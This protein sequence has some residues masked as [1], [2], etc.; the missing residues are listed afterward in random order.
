MGWAKRLWKR[1][2]AG[3]ARGE[4]LRQEE[5]ERLK[6]LADAWK[7]TAKCKFDS[8]K[9]QKPEDEFGK[10]FIQHGAMCY[11]N[12]AMEL[13]NLISSIQNEILANSSGDQK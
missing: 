5:I 8:A 2:F 4:G 10:R 1:W 13:G 9:A 3:K 11:N 7:H 6:M 12:C